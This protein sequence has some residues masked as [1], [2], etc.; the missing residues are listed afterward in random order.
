LKFPEFKFNVP[1]LLSISRVILVPL[2]LYLI[3]LKTMTGWIWALVV[4]AIAS[5]T[6]LLDG[7][8]ARKLDQQSEFGEFIDPL[9]DKF[10]VISALLALMILDPYLQIFDL[11]MIFVIIGR[12]VLLTVMRYLALKKGE[13]LKTS[14]FGKVKTAFQMISVVLII[15][16]YMGRKSDILAVHKSIPYWIMLAVTILTALSGIRYLITNWHLFS[17]KK[18]ENKQGKDN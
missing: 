4:F 13:A 5:F 2:F 18:D 10:L 9:A 3:S 15:M 12:D 16:V 8:T 17:L 1:N 11:W 6:D 7:W 14:H